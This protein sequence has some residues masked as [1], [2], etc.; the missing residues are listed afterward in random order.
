M[1]QSDDRKWKRLRKMKQI[2]G[3]KNE[4]YKAILN[5]DQFAELLKQQE[6]M[7]EKLKEWAEARRENQA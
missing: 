7:K 4:A 3:E 1:L 2:Q 5:N 6:K